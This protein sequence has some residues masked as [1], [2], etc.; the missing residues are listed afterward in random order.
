MIKLARLA[1]AAVVV[2]MASCTAMPPE[3]VQLSASLGQ[4]IEKSHTAHV[5]MVNKY[6]DTFVDKIDKFALGD[7]KTTFINN[8]KKLAKQKDDN[9][10]DFTPAQYDAIMT[11]IMAQRLEWLH[12]I[13]TNRQQILRELADYYTLMDRV[14]KEVTNIIR[15]AAG[16]DSAK[17]QL[18]KDL[19][20]QF[21][22]RAK[23]IEDKLLGTNSAVELMLN[24]AIKK[25]FGDQ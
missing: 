5:N 3:A 4:M 24:D 7:Y 23:E 6:F 17:N 16:V 11:R 15:S 21:G 2:A 19:T 25:I 9:F 14:N 12:S 1:I 20:T 22:Q 13:E 18:I 10:I 8:A